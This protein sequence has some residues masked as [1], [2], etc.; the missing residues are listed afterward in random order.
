[1]GS[2]RPAGLAVVAF[3]LLFWSVFTPAV[4][5]N[6]VGHMVVTT[7]YELFGTSDLS[8]GGHVTWTLTG[9]VGPP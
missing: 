9:A 4:G 7:D 2:A 3:F 6:P 1:M 5:Q 8:G